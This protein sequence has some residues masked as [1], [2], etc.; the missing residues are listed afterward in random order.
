MM[1]MS[2]ATQIKATLALPPSPHTCI[3]NIDDTPTMQELIELDVPTQRDPI[4][5][6]SK[7]GPNYSELGICLLNDNDGIVLQELKHDYPLTK[8]KLD[9]IF[10]S[11][12]QGKGRRYGQKT[13][14]WGRLIDCLNVA[15][16]R[17]LADNLKSRLCD[18]K[19]SAQ[20]RANSVYKENADTLQDVAEP[21]AN[22]NYHRFSA[23]LDGCSSSVLGM[24]QEGIL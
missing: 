20:K 21:V 2:I 12:L 7:I 18:Y 17:Y 3:H 1:P 22:I 13:N 15:E 5:I 14:T 8:D 10:S 24:P 4:R 6:K 16:L 9:A 11:W 23:E 19:D